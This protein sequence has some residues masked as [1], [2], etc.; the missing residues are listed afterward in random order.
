MLNAVLTALPNIFAAAVVLILA[1]FIGRLLGRFVATLLSGLGFNRFFESI[2]LYRPGAAAAISR[3]A[4]DAVDETTG[5]ST[6]DTPTQI[7]R[8]TPADVVGW[9]VTASVILFAAMQAANLLGFV[10]LA[11]LISDFVTAAFQVLVGLA[12]FAIG[13]YLSSLAANAIRS[14]NMS[15]ANIL[16]PVARVAILVFAGALALRQMGIADS[17]V[18][19]AFGL[20]LGA[21]AVAAALAFGLGGRDAARQQLE[22]WQDQATSYQMIPNTGN[23]T[24]QST[25]RDTSTNTETPYVEPTEPFDNTTPPPA[26]PYTP[27]SG[28]EPPFANPMD[29]GPIEPDE[30]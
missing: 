29:E 13:L 10:F 30:I 7:P 25:A 17:I 8:T 24:R 9:L 20:M 28:Q 6:S 5:T 1:Y 19:L 18:N 22:R 26:G 15:Q 14:S 12:I 23:Q 21:V 2:G 11:E 4:R 16:A 27:Y 3:A